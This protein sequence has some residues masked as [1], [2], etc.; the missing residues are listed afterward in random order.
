MNADFNNVIVELVVTAIQKHLNTAEV[1]QTTSGSFRLPVSAITCA[2][3]TQF[4]VQASRFTYC[5]PRN[6]LGPWTSVEVMTLTEGAAPKFWEHDAGENLAGYVPIEAVALE[7]IRR[8]NLAL[9]A[10]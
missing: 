5:S 7:V 4:S 1:V 6:D 9:T 2:D 3:G 8:G 10:E